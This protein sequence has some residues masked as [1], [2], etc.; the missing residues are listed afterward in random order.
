[1]CF[2][3]IHLSKPQP[4]RFLK[5]GFQSLFS[6]AILLSLS[7]CLTRNAHPW[8]VWL[9]GLSICSRTEDAHR[10]RFDSSPGN[11]PQLQAQ[12]LYII[13]YRRKYCI[14]ITTATQY[15]FLKDHYLDS[16]FF[17]ELTLS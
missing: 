11:R 14:S 1:M 16:E 6:S 15:N 7:F 3:R 8:L 17:L 10:P 9:R 2:P 12:S 5:G 4:T 13:I